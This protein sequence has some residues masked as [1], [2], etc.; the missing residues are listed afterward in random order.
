MYFKTENLGFSLKRKPLTSSYST[1]KKIK[2]Y[3]SEVRRG[4]DD[5]LLDL[6]TF[7]EGSQLDRYFK[8]P[9]SDPQSCIKLSNTLYD[10]NRI[11]A[12]IIDYYSNMYYNRYLVIPRKIRDTKSTSEYNKIYSEM[13]EYVEGI[14]IETVI[15]KLL[16]DIFKNGEVFLYASGDKK[17]K[18]LSTMILPNKYCRATLV[19]QFGTQE[20][21]FDYTFFESLG[22]KKEDLIELL[23]MFPEEFQVGYIAYLNDKVNSR[24]QH[25]NPKF[26]TSIAM[27]EEGFPSFLSIFYDIIDYK[28]Y[29]LNELDRNTNLLERLVTQEIDLEKTGLDLTEVQ[30]LHDS[31]AEIICRNRGTTLVTTVG[32][33][34][35][36][37]LQEDIGQVNET[38]AN[39]FK[40][41]FDNAGINNALF[42]GD[43]DLSLQT[44]LKQDLMYVWGF[45]Q[46]IENFYNIAINNVRNFS[47]YQLSFKILP[48][49]IYNEAEKMEQLHQSAT[50]GVG[51]LDYIVASG[52]K[53]VDLEASLE[54]EE[55]LDLS[56]R[57]VPLQSSHTQS[58]SD[59][60]EKEAG[61]DAETSTKEEEET[62]T[63]EEN[64]TSI[65]EEP[66]TPAEPSKEDSKTEDDNEDS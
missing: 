13:L 37:Q 16:I 7:T 47:N 52:T 38:L 18:T 53:Q 45:I 10:T 65:E 54:L 40:T 49:S 66:I 2:N 57:L 1:V 44:S 21:D 20:I 22:L 43:S 23:T 24:W 5:V 27:N 19:T 12:K 51:V 64:K 39:S 30:E 32:S 15:P 34:E 8:N 26:A 63:E 31:M 59:M 61:G 41:I 35:V 6:S 56:N 42:T 58:S 62:S 17:S 4:A 46:K 11:Y 9:G 29:K 36:Q 60:K 48:I 55:Y 14:N 33:I 3:F 25:L 50:L 28:T